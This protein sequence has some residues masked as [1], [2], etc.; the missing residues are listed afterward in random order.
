MAWTNS[1]LGRIGFILSPFI[2]SAFA[3][4]WGW[5]RTVPWLALL[6]LCSLAL[7]WRMVQEDKHAATELETAKQTVLEQTQAARP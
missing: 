6:P 7:I 1:L 5:A 3:E 4:K 2:V